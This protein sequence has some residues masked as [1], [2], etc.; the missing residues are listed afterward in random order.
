[1]GFYVLRMPV[2]EGSISYKNAHS[3]V[4]GYNRYNRYTRW[5]EAPL[6]L[7]IM[8]ERVAATFTI[9]RVCRYCCH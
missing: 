7:D 9:I 4:S 3:A 8:A 1:M 2:N 6:L 5:L